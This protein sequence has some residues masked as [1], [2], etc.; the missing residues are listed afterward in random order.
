MDTKIFTTK[1]PER[2][3]SDPQSRVSPDYEML[4]SGFSGSMPEWDDLVLKT[5]NAFGYGFNYDQLADKVLDKIITVLPDSEKIANS[6]ETLEDIVTEL[7]N[8]Y[9]HQFVEMLSVVNKQ[10]DKYWSGELEEKELID[11]GFV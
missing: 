10:T 7:S 4:V 5:H 3:N 9:D 8:K 2:K 6:G 1:R 11:Y